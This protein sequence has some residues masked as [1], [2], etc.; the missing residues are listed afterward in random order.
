M[1]VF[2]VLLGALIFSLMLA[3][4]FSHTAEFFARGGFAGWK[5]I[6]GVVACEALFFLSNTN[7]IYCKLY[8]RNVPTPV[9]IAAVVS[10]I[11]IGYANISVGVLKGLEYGFYV[12]FEAVLIGLLVIVVMVVSELVVS[13]AIM[14][15]VQRN[16]DS[17][18]NNRTVEQSDSG[19]SRQEGGQG[20]TEGWTSGQVL[21]HP[22]KSGQTQ[23]P[24]RQTDGQPF[25]QSDT[26]TDKQTDTFP[27]VS[28][29][30]ATCV[31]DAQ[32]DTQTNKQTDIG[33]GADSTD[34]QQSAQTDGQ[35]NRQTEVDAVGQS[36]SEK[37][38]RTVVQSGSDRRID[39]RTKGK[40][41]RQTKVSDKAGEASGKREGASDRSGEVSDHPI[42][43]AEKF[44]EE[45]GDY[46][47]VRKLAELAGITRHKAHKLLQQLKAKAS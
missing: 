9:R 38:I 5:A 41:S 24:V 14:S 18:S 13:S 34:A 45:N 22:D 23:V 25:G 30:A 1:K 19:Q 31:A 12:G 47:S 3:L 33:Q 39:S 43:I 17:H 42:M 28:G 27:K 20:Q 32:P 35:T 10:A 6:V 4:S 8:G 2:N 29:N 7:I 46:P 11:T 40:S 21:G 44:R 37:E 16:P 26:K 36:D 15:E